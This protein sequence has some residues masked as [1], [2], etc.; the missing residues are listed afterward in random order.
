[1]SMNDPLAD[2]LTRIRNAGMVKFESIKM[3]LSRV[4][5][6][7]ANILKKEGYISDY[8]IEKDTVQGTLHLDLKYDQDGKRVITGLKRVSTPGRRVYAK[9]DKIPKILSGLGIS[10]IS[11]SK[12]VVSDR[13]A[14]E[15]HLGGEILCNVW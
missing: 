9:Y 5:V 1:M 4:K 13:E 3:P 11:T 2:M 6:D 7:V 12:G 15:R 8:H 14:R 10:V